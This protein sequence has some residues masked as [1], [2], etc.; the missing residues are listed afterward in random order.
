MIGGEIIDCGDTPPDLEEEVSDSQFD[1]AVDDPP[2]EDHV[3][4]VARLSLDE[5]E[6]QPRV[7]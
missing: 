7:A 4:T 1:D 3:R 5:L 6:V 2:V